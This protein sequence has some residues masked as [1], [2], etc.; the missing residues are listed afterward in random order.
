MAAKYTKAQ[1]NHN[2]HLQHFLD[3]YCGK[4]NTTC[5]TT[6]YED[7]V[8]ANAQ[9]SFET[10]RRAVGLTDCRAP[11]S[12]PE[13]AWI[14]CADRVE[15]WDEL[16]QQKGLKGSHWLEMCQNGNEVPDYDVLRP[17]PPRP[18]HH[19]PE[20]FFGFGGAFTKRR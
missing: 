10:L 19:A 12:A 13:S 14:P 5:L 8:G 2:K 3:V 16:L 11:K 17:H 15:N 1:M 7:L 18:N 9:A 6:A 20:T 4:F